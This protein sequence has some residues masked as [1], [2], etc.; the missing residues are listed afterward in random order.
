MA[1]SC[2]SKP[3]HRQCFTL[4][5]PRL[6]KN[7]LSATFFLHCLIFLSNFKFGLKSILTTGKILNQAILTNSELLKSN[8]SFTQTGVFILGLSPWRS[9]SRVYLLAMAA[10]VPVLPARQFRCWPGLRLTPGHQLW[11]EIHMLSGPL[12]DFDRYVCPFAKTP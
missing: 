5:R 2:S 12:F 3:L 4:S 9:N 6:S 1:S 8:R 10:T 7:T 11:Q